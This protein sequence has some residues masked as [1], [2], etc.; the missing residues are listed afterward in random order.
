MGQ[1]CTRI[2]TFSPCWNQDRGQDA[3]FDYGRPGIDYN[4]DIEDDMLRLNDTSLYSTCIYTKK[5]GLRIN[6]PLKVE[7]CWYSDQRK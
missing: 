3:N 1:T 4:E 7:D 2:V 6:N 5:K